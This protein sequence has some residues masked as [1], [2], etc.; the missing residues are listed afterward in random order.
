MVYF[1]LEHA[2]LITND[3][4]S[5]GIKVFLPSACGHLTL[6]HLRRLNLT[7]ANRIHLVEPQW[8]PTVESQAIGRILRLGQQKQVYVTRY[9][10]HDSIEKYVQNKQS[11]KMKLA[12]MGWDRE[13]NLERQNALE[14]WSFLGLS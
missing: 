9:I 11:E 8:N 13:N 7:V 6:T 1:L 12:E 10:V 2:F 5:A 14:L 4:N 3:V